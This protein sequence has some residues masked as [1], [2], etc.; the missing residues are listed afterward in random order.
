MKH[1]LTIRENSSRSLPLIGVAA[2]LPLVWLGLSGGGFDAVVRGQVGIVIWWVL[3]LGLALSLIPLGAIGQ[4]GWIAL[5]ALT[6]LSVWTG[7]SLLW[8]DAAGA[9]WEELG[10]LATYTGVLALGLCVRRD[11]EGARQIIKGVTGALVLL[12]L[13][14]LASRLVPGWFPRDSADVFDE[15]V[16]LSYPV[17]YWNGLAA[18]SVM[19][20]PLLLAAATLARRRAVR[21]LAAALL[22]AL[23]LTGYLT[24]SRSAIVFA[25]IAILI[26]LML[27]TDRLRGSVTLVLGALGGLVLMFAASARG[28]FETGVPAA[29]VGGEG[30]AM[31]AFVLVV[32]LAVGVS[33]ALIDGRLGHRGA[34]EPDLA[35]RPGTLRRARWLAVGATLIV[36]VGGGLALG[37]AG[38]I[39]SGWEQ[40]KNPALGVSAD[41]PATDRL[42]E[43]GGNG[44]YQYWGVALDQAESDLVKGTGA[45]TYEVS[46]LRTR[47]FNTFIRNAHSLYLETLGE[48]GVV[49]LELILTLVLLVLIAA[50]LRTRAAAAERTA[51]AA[52]TAACFAFA[53]WAGVDWL[54]QVPVLPAAFLLLAAALIGGSAAAGSATSFTRPTRRLRIT[55]AAV[56]VLAIVAAAI[57]M[58]VAGQLKASRAAADAG[59]LDQALLD[60]R[61]A[62]AVQ[63]GS[64]APRREEARVL[65][66]RGELPAAVVAANKAATLEPADWQNWLVVSRLERATGDDAA[67]TLA[68]RK[69]MAGNPLSP[70]F[71]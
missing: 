40:F 26:Y 54:W 48:L 13:V 21:A 46:W 30:L 24:F 43:V 63:P 23:L 28:A 8:S 67:A 65:A 11:A 41:A 38:A 22:P 47:P 51:F 42:T 50:V 68:M 57:P 10:R 9:T 19:T 20:L 66:L 5:V 39:S 33:H 36:L 62:I 18:L 3:I 25:A 69:A 15:A 58:V 55:I 64:A 32:T 14:A 17:G 34:P 45:G 12:A 7:L 53:L 6:G 1:Y 70:V 27:S 71:D 56:G 61:Q 59:D 44:R 4:R 37:G 2:F 29:A 16:R 35:D 49:G 31:L 60:A 52:A